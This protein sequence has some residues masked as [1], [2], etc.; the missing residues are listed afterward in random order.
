GKFLLGS[1]FTKVTWAKGLDANGRPIPAPNQSPT[2]EGTIVYPGVQGGTN[3][4]SPSYSPR[5]GL[6]YVST[7]QDYFMNV[8]KLPADY[9]PGQRYTGGAPRSPVPSLQRGPINTW[10]SENGYGALLAIDPNTGTKRWEF[11][12]TDVS[13]SGILSTASDLLFTGNREGYFYAFDARNG[14]LLWRT[15]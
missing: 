15:Q 10:T 13:G 14:T 6:F 9:V 1:P 5:T 8:A 11:K 2:E 12:M 3:W 4:Y 7:W